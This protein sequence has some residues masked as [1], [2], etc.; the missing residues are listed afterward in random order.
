MSVMSATVAPPEAK[1]VDV[2]TKAA[3]AAFE[4]AH[5]ITFS[6]SVRLDVSRITFTG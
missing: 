5:A 1:P 2:F 3:P 6:S 4:S